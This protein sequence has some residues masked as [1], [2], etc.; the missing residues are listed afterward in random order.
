MGGLERLQVSSPMAGV[1][2][3]RDTA[4]HSEYCLL[5]VSKSRIVGSH[6]KP[7]KS[8]RSNFDPTVR[9]QQVFLQGELVLDKAT[10]EIRGDLRRDQLIGTVAWVLSLTLR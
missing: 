8:S 1:R 2:T 9:K 3:A 6:S 5:G 7:V 4:A 10:V